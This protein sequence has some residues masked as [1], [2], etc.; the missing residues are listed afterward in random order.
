MLSRQGNRHTTEKTTVEQGSGCWHD[1]P[2]LTYHAITGKPPPEPNEVL[3]L[4]LTISNNTNNPTARRNRPDVHPCFL[5]PGQPPAQLAGAFVNRAPNR[6]GQSPKIDTDTCDLLAHQLPR[7][8][9]ESSESRQVQE[10]AEHAVLTDPSQ[11]LTSL[12]KAVRLGTHGDPQSQGYGAGVAIFGNST[13]LQ[14]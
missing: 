1:P 14:G 13:H 4:T 7:V 10:P 5:V 8:T 11:G 6:G 3:W 9:Y 2:Q 12:Y